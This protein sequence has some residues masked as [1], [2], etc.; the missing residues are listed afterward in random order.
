MGDVTN[1]SLEQANVADSQHKQDIQD[2]NNGPPSD[3]VNQAPP[4]PPDPAGKGVQGTN[5]D[6]SNLLK[7]STNT[8]PSSVDP[9]QENKADKSREEMLEKMRVSM[10]L[11]K[12]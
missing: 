9:K 10:E 4:L 6:F 11:W 7:D 3:N 5:L 1:V 2:Q 12:Q 8:G